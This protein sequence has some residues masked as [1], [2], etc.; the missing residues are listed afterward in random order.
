MLKPRNY[1]HSSP[2]TL[3]KME[4]GHVDCS[5]QTPSSKAVQLMLRSNPRGPR[6]TR[7]QCL[8]DIA[9]LDHFP[10]E[11]L[12]Q[13]RNLRLVSGNTTVIFRT[14]VNLL[15]V[16]LDKAVTIGEGTFSLNFKKLRAPKHSILVS[17]RNFN[18]FR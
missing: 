1:A 2:N 11:D 5:T 18:N 15:D 16:D 4:E 7:Y 12:K 3:V 6:C 13:I 10:N 9:L 17:Y 8:P 14:P